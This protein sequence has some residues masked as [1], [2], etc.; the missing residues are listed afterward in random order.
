MDINNNEDLTSTQLL[1]Y[2]LS[3]DKRFLML[4]EKKFINLKTIDLLTREDERFRQAYC[5]SCIFDR[6]IDN[7][8]RP[9]LMEELKELLSLSIIELKLDEQ[10]NY[11]IN[12]LRSKGQASLV[13]ILISHFTAQQQQSLIRSKPFNRLKH[14]LM[15]CMRHQSQCIHVNSISVTLKRAVE[16]AFTTKQQPLS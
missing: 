14:L 1:G 3:A 15:Q 8:Q 5:I 11:I 9:E 7:R 2:E 6:Y 16:H 13:N 4:T 10:G 12:V